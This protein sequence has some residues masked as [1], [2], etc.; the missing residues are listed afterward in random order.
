MKTKK[1]RWKQVLLCTFLL[2][3]VFVNIV[4]L[5]WMLSS[6]IK[7]GTELFTREIHL[8]P[9]A[10]TLDNF[11][12]ALEDFPFFTWVKNSVGTTAGISLLRIAVSILTAFAL[13]YYRTR[14]NAV[15]FYMIIATMVVPFQVTMIPNYILVSKL[16][17]LNTWSAVILPNVA[18]AS[19]FFFLRQ[20]LRGIPRDYFEVGQIEGGNSF[21]IMRNVV[22]GMCKGAVSAMFILAIIDAWNI[23]FWP[24]LVMKDTAAKTLTIG[25]RNFVDIE[26]GSR[27]GEFM[28]TATMAS[29]PVIGIYLLMQRNIIDAFIASGLKG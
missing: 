10:P 29:L 16:G 28:A 20:H 14:F 18:G 7:P 22:F 1:I 2:L 23:Y 24:L 8:I 13:S 4:P 5:F 9:Y 25:L 27:W 21:W 19:S 26:M 11:K 6:A 17:L 15:V 3:I 12:T